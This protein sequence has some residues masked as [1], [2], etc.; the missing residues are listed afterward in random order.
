MLLVAAALESTHTQRKTKFAP[1]FCILLSLSLSLSFFALLASSAPPD[2]GLARRNHGHVEDVRSRGQAD[3]VQHGRGD[4]LRG[5]EALALLPPRHLL[6]RP[7]WVLVSQRPSEV[8]L[9]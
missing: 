6:G 9:R 7:V 8:L 2:Q 5:D 1:L 3:H 4:I